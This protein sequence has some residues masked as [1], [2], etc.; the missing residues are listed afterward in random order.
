VIFIK[1][2]IFA[3]QQKQKTMSKL[4]NSLIWGLGRGIGNTAS[5]RTTEYI[6]S[7]IINPKSKFRNRIE[8]FDLGGDFNL[9]KKKLLVLI[10][11]FHEE[12]VINADKLPMMQVGTYRQPDINMIDNKIIFFEQLISDERHNTQ[13]DIVVNFWNT[14]KSQ[15]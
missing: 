14:V 1:L 9:A 7:K 3:I 8:K 5:K 15:L 10:E 13:Y 4:V 6:G 11:M 2:S 12:Y